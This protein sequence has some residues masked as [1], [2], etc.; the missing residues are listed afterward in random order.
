MDQLLGK[1]LLQNPNVN[2]NAGQGPAPGVG[3]IANRQPKPAPPT[4]AIW[5]NPVVAGHPIPKP[6]T[7]NDNVTDLL[8]Q[9]QRANDS[10]VT[11]GF[12]NG[13][14]TPPQRSSPTTRVSVVPG[15]PPQAAGLNRTNSGTLRRGG[16]TNAIQIQT[17]SEPPPTSAFPPAPP[18]PPPPPPVEAPAPP[19]D[20]PAPPPPQEPAPPATA[21]TDPVRTTALPAAPRG[22]AP[23]P[24]APSSPE[25]VA[26]Q[27]ADFPASSND[28]ECA[29]VPSLQ[30]S[31]GCTAVTDTSDIG[32]VE[33]ITQGT[34]VVK[35]RGGYYIERPLCVVSRAV[36]VVVDPQSCL[37][38]KEYQRT[39]RYILQR[40]MVATWSNDFVRNPDKDIATLGLTK[41]D[42][43]FS[44]TKDH[45]VDGKKDLSAVWKAYPEWSASTTVLL[46]CNL[47][48][49]SKHAL[50]VCRCRYLCCVLANFF[51]DTHT[52]TRI[53]T[54]AIILPPEQGDEKD[55]AAAGDLYKIITVCT[56][57]C[58]EAHVSPLI[59][60]TATHHYHPLPAAELDPVQEG[61]SRPHLREGFGQLE[62]GMRRTAPAQHECNPTRREC[63]PS[64]RASLCMSRSLSPACL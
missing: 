2:S 17:K 10:P 16:S 49:T 38:R 1:F 54:Q 47:Q 46:D 22:P 44:F 21:P 52:R 23:F 24:E 40:T 25:P 26:V 13:E 12:P 8:I 41:K 18:T 51:F 19:A 29:Y 64:R 63:G 36:L 48:A 14:S 34:V 27:L 5:N 32:V 35:C 20:P 31:M 11:R 6:V 62:E 7:P 39:M 58:G 4:T 53:H 37:K 50:N 15:G 45:V 57:P 61:R 55:K 33:E 28:A 59:T 42:V 60:P 3:G 43:V 9:A 56:F 30:V